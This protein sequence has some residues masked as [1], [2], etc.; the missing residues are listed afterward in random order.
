[1]QLA[2]DTHVHIYPFYRVE[3]ALRAILKNLGMGNQS[4][5]KVACLT[6][7][8]DCDLYASLQ[9]SPSAQILEQFEIEPTQDSLIVRDK[10]REDQFH[11]LPGQQIITSENIE[12]LALS[13]TKRVDEGQPAAD[14]VS[15]ILDAGGVP[16]VAWAPGKWFFQ[17][18]RVV[19]SLLDRF[20][21]SE[22]ALGDTTLRPIGWT[23]PKIISDA[24]KSGYRILYG[25]DP[26]PFVGEEN[27]PGSYFSNIEI[28]SGNSTTT[29]NPG[30]I[31]SQL[32]TMDVKISAAGTRGSLPEVLL[33]LYRN[34]RAPKPSR[35][36]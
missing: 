12:I 15:A 9:K 14:T 26:L 36:T 20:G 29:N 21:P 25:S 11:L 18:G 5:V 31:I 35:E 27:R 33:R 23:T 28:D 10:S 7:R 8:Y 13:C 32:L 24:R 17:R 2:V 1:M 34:N 16:V 6:E 19:V 22:L 30:Q 4:G 3:R